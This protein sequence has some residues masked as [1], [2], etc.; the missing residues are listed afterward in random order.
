LLIGNELDL[1]L[2]GIGEREV[3]LK[4]AVV[5]TPKFVD[6]VGTVERRMEVVT[7]YASSKGMV[8]RDPSPGSALMLTVTRPRRREV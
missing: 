1:V 7:A 8:W 2:Y 4:L 5:S 3:T 6:A